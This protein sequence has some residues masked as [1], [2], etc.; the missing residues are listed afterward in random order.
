MCHYCGYT[1]AIPALCPA[2]ESDALR[3]SGFGTERIEDEIAALFPDARIARMDLD[4][5]RTRSA[6]ERLILDFQEHRTDILVGTQ[7]V[8]KGLDFE[9]VSLVGILSA[10]TM[11]NQPDFRAYERAFQM[12]AQVAGRAGRR[13]ERGLVILQTRNADLPLIHQVIHNDYE[14]M[15]RTQM[16]ERRQFAYPPFVRM[17][18]M[19]VKHRHLSVAEMLA[20][21]AAERLKRLFGTRVL[22]PDEP[23]VSRI[24][25][26]YIRR[27]IIKLEL[28]LPMAKAKQLLRQTADALMSEKAYSS[29]QIYFDVDPL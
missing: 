13:D 26:L 12:M 23:A 7:M 22:G 3:Q 10:E 11:L 19:Y 21:D 14:S 18:V 9:H 29:A 1:T 28:S 17:V 6:Y 16:E 5:T 20:R 8:S 4:T 2:C 24:S 15:Y 25:S 27:I